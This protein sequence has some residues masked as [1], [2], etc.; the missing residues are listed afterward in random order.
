MTNPQGRPALLEAMKYAQIGTMLV[1]P[2]GILGGIG[3]WLDRRL[4]SAPWLLLL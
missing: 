2:M 3:Y 1:V 4:G